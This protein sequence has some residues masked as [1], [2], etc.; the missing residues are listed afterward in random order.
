VADPADLTDLPTLKQ[1]L[2]PLNTTTQ[3][4]A[5]LSTTI[6]GLSR[7]MLEYIGRDLR[8]ATYSE[9]R[10]GNARV[11]MRTLH[12]PIIS[13]SSLSINGAVVT[14]AQAANA[15]GYVYDDKYIYLRNGP[16]GGGG[17]GAF[18]GVF[19]ARPPQGIKQV[20]IDYTA[21]YV[22]PG[23]I[24]VGMLP[25]WQAIT[26]Y[27]FG[28]QVLPGNGSFYTAITGGLSG[29]TA[30]T[31]PAAVGATVADGGVVWLNAGAYVAPPTGATMLNQN[32]V[33]TALE[34]CAYHF[35]MR[36]RV[37]QTSM[38]E[39]PQ[40]ISFTVAAMPAYIK[41]LLDPERSWVLFG[42]WA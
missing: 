15:P 17:G 19:G 1:F 41:A 42:D 30:P 33:M 26:D 20:Q 34:Y 5:V 36:A 31:F 21:G 11:S 8:A 24:A 4:D 29:G 3:A 38:G 2:V 7:T 12:W 39:G 23:Q 6:T 35:N 10:N 9:I 16:Y 25:A 14:A 27:A 18:P 22:T 13:V 37:G 32:V 40:R 28:A